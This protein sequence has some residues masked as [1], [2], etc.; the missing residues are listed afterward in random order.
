MGIS[1][2]CQTIFSRVKI[3]AFDIKIL[4]WLIS[5]VT[6]VVRPKAIALQFV[7][8]EIDSWLEIKGKSFVKEASQ[9]GTRHAIIVE[10]Y[11]PAKTIWLA[12]QNLTLIYFNDF[13]DFIIWCVHFVIYNSTYSAYELVNGERFKLFT[14]RVKSLLFSK[15][16]P[17]LDILAINLAVL[18]TE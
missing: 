18:R 11:S 13:C 6:A 10:E 7:V 4:I 9:E 2:K 12:V 16:R 8:L 3:A 15:E 17:F 1:L 14:A 5:D